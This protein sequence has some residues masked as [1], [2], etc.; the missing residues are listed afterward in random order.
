MRTLE[1]LSTPAGILTRRRE[2]VSTRPS[3]PQARQGAPG[4]TPL[5]PQLGQME[6]N[7]MNP[8]CF[9]TRPCPPQV[10]Q[11]L[12]LEAA[13]MPL[14]LQAAQACLWLIWMVVSMPLAASMKFRFME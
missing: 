12:C 7:F 3:P 1:S 5:P 2:V 10:G 13:S 4:R 14:P 8:V 9:C 11:T 6:P